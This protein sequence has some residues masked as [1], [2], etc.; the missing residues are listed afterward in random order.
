MAL[1]E[2]DP[3][4]SHSPLSRTEYAVFERAQLSN[5]GCIG[6]LAPTADGVTSNIHDLHQSTPISRDGRT[7]EANVTRKHMTLT[8][9]AG[10]LVPSSSPFSSVN[11]APDRLQQLRR[12]RSF[13]TPLDTMMAT[14]RDVPNATTTATSRLLSSL[15]PYVQPTVQPAFSPQLPLSPLCPTTSSTLSS[16]NRPTAQLFGGKY[17][18]VARDDRR[19]ASTATRSGRRFRRWNDHSSESDDG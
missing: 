17:V 5:A 9:C 12:S 7:H 11:A 3:T 15:H 14:E 18:L 8:D 6:N 10:M 16:S 4:S 1:T 2:S 19:E 13:S